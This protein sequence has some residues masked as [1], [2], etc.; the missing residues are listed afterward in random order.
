MPGKKVKHCTRLFPIFD[1]Y[2]VTAIGTKKTRSEGCENRMKLKR[3]KYLKKKLKSPEKGNSSE[4]L[5]QNDELISKQSTRPKEDNKIDVTQEA[6]NAL[7]NISTNFIY[8]LRY[9]K[10]RQTI[11]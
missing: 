1:L 7:K 8:S 2:L 6:A 10:V 4:H 9:K 11:C 3:E 5:S